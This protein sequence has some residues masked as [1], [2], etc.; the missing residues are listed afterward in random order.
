MRRVTTNNRYRDRLGLDRRRCRAAAGA[1]RPARGVNDGGV[2]RQRRSRPASPRTSATAPS[3]PSSR[4]AAGWS[5]AARS[6]TVTP[7]AG[8]GAGKAVTRKFLFAFNATTGALDTGF[9]PAV[10][11]EVDSIV[12]TRRRHRRLRRRQVHLR[13]RRLDPAGRVQPDHRRP[14]RGVQARRSTARSSDM[15]LLGN[16]LL[17]AGTFTTVNERRRTAGSSP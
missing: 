7:T 11:G 16:R 3:R 12:P 10:N 8:A 14:G 1:A 6:P 5:S 17:V 13:R 9:V 4:S 2:Y 15:A